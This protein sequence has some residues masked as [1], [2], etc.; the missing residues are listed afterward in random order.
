MGNSGAKL[1]IVS[2]INSNHFGHFIDINELRKKL[3][4]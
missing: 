1:S 4:D 2:E 3:K